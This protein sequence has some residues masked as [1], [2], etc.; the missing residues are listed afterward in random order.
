M[1]GSKSTGKAVA[2][3]CRATPWL[4]VSDMRTVSSLA[5]LAGWLCLA[6]LSPAQEHTPPNACAA[7]RPLSRP[8]RHFAVHQPNVLAGLLQIASEHRLCLGVEL[9]GPDLSAS[10]VRLAGESST[11]GALLRRLLANPRGYV[12]AEEDRVIVIRPRSR[13]EGNL[14]DARLR[15][16]RAHRT[17]VQSLS[18]GLFMQLMVERHPTTQGFAGSYPTGD[19]RSLAGP[20][21]ERDKTVRKLLNA[22]VRSSGEGMWLAMRTAREDVA[23]LPKPWIVLEFTRP[24]DR[25]VAAMQRLAAPLRQQR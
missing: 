5:A 25:N 20:F 21:D 18:L 1:A 19:R 7:V 17:D 23:G 16:F 22:M 3:L 8:V 24:F 10:P 14:L 15:R 11:V 4:G 9:A 2:T 6:R 13:P 12:I